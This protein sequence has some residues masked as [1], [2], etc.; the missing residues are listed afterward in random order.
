MIKHN[1]ITTY[2]NNIQRHKILGTPEST[3][4]WSLLRPMIVE[5]QAKKVFQSGALTW[6]PRET[7][8]LSSSLLPCLLM[9]GCLWLF[10]FGVFCVHTLPPWFVMLKISGF[11]GVYFELLRSLF[12]FF[13]FV[14]TS[15]LPTKRSSQGLKFTGS[16]ALL[17]HPPFDVSSEFET[18]EKT[19]HHSPRICFRRLAGLKSQSLL[20]DE[21]S[22]ST[23]LV[24]LA[25]AV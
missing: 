25:F 9:S 22:S 18:K 12:S 13:L 19:T 16:Q 15:F 14:W 6:K 21:G 10:L 5:S 1:G 20:I 8:P 3:G 23:W 7:R 11:L 2:Y 4:P 17:Q 24:W